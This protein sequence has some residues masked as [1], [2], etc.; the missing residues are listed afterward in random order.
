MPAAPKNKNRHDTPERYLYYDVLSKPTKTW[1]GLKHQRHLLQGMLRE[2]HIL[3]RTAVLHPMCIASM[4]NFGK[5]QLRPFSD[6]FDLDASRVLQS[7]VATKALDWIDKDDLDFE[8]IAP[9][10]TKIIGAEQNHFIDEDTDRRYQ[11]IIRDTSTMI[12][13]KWEPAGNYMNKRI[14]SGEL[15]QRNWNV[16]LETTALIRKTAAGV[17]DV[18]GDGLP[19]PLDKD[20]LPR[21]QTINGRRQMP[22]GAYACLHLRLG[23]RVVYEYE[24]KSWVRSDRFLKM[25]YRFL[26]TPEAPLY[27]MSNMEDTVYH[28]EL[29]KRYRVFTARDFAELNRRLP[30]PGAIADDEHLL[31]REIEYKAHLPGGVDAQGRSLR[32]APS[33]LA[34]PD[35]PDNTFIYAVEELIYRN[36]YAR[37][38]T[39]FLNSFQFSFDNPYRAAA[40]KAFST[41]GDTNK[42]SPAPEAGDDSIPPAGDTNKNSPRYLIHEHANPGGVLRNKQR[43]SALLCEAARLDR[44]AVIT[45]WQMDG[46]YNKGQAQQRSPADFVDLEQ[47]RVYGEGIDEQG[48]S[49]RWIMEAQLDSGERRAI[50]ADDEAADQADAEAPLLVR[51][52]ET[53]EQEERAAAQPRRAE[54][55]AAE[56]IRT[57][58][59]DIQYRL[60]GE[61]PP[62]P[63]LAFGTHSWSE[64]K[65]GPGI[66]HCLQ[67][68][69]PE[70]STRRRQISEL[71]IFARLRRISIRDKKNKLRFYAMGD[72]TASARW[73]NLKKLVNVHS[74]GDFETLR[75]FLNSENGAC[76]LFT[77]F[78]VEALVMRDARFKILA[79]PMQLKEAAVTDP[80][81]H[82]TY[83]IGYMRIVRKQILKALGLSKYVAK[84]RKLWRRFNN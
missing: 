5:R 11:M 83:P 65:N 39:D 80:D 47:A 12:G 35:D 52:F 22:A 3:N 10:Q 19:P 50:G 66:Y 51:R 44:I 38:N 56:R 33:P 68:P 34:G 84:A 9:A 61:C 15:P 81:Y 17:I 31:A 71:K 76:D 67:L 21:Y 69:A 14:T 72:E 45:P 24:W 7:G 37:I 16:T 43:L 82:I 42:N 13:D 36:A 58:A 77:V 75:P 79:S 59:A 2:A 55:P 30:P 53:R 40:R 74:A 20:F 6:I 18:L 28:D 60:G 70:K 23:D 8:S 48:A 1:A 62:Q 46:R 41:S 64:V 4:H 73:H 57:L 54:L 49:A 26:P 32:A 63:R 25:I 27:I 29:R 78:A